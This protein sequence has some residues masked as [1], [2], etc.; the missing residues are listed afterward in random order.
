MTDMRK[1]A[2]SVV[3]FFFVLIAIGVVMD[4]AHYIEQNDFCMICHEREYD[5]STTPGDSLDFAHFQNEISCAGCHKGHDRLVFTGLMARMIVLDVTGGSSPPKSKEEV[6]LENMERCLVCHDNYRLLTIE[7][8]LDPHSN[9]TDCSKCHT[10]HE[11]GMIDEQCAK[12]HFV[13][14][15]TLN[16]E[17][18][19][20]SKKGCGFCHPSHG[21]VME[22]SQC[23]GSFHQGVFV[24]CDECHTDA[25]K[26]ADIEFTEVVLEKSLCIMCHENVNAT[27]NLNPSKHANLDCIMCHPTHGQK[28]QC[29]KCH[30]AHGEA[31]TRVDCFVCHKGH[32]PKNVKYSSVTPN[33]LCVEC[34]ESAGKKLLSSVNEHSKLDCVKC[35][36]SHAQ[37]PLCMDCHGTP[38]TSTTTDCERC[39]VSAHELRVVA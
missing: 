29:S 24:D 21:Y 10:G 26:P 37:V 19:K 6:V 15:T 14:Y 18:G 11:R 12:C 34:H 16:E 17:G 4:G 36:P 28:Q 33:S 30:K 27:F 31:S 13:Q 2:V 9:V 38:H 8:P 22:C 3:M 23:H 7:R 35:H 20:H 5:S 39:H 25:H 32:T 1:V